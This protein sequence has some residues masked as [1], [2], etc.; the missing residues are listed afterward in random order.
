MAAEPK[1]N[2]LLVDDEPAN[3]LALEAVLAGLGQNLVK[4][5]S[6]AEALGCVLDQ[7]FA[8]IL[9]DVQ[10]PVMNGFETASRIRQRQRSAHTPIIFLTAQYET[11]QHVS[12][13]YAVGGV[14][15]LLKP[16]DPHV[17]RSKVS[18]FIDLFRMTFRLKQQAETIQRLNQDLSSRVRELALVNQQLAVASQQ[19]EQARDQAVTASNLK[20]SFLAN[21]SNEIRTPMNG[22]IGMIDSLLR[23]PLNDE[24]R[25]FANIIRDS[26]EVLMDIINDILDFSKIEAGRLDL[27]IVD[28]DTLHMVE[29]TVEL[30]A[31]RARSKGLSLMTYLAPAVPHTLRGDPSRLR[32]VLL[33]LIGNAIKFTE[34]GE[35]VLKVSLESRTSRQAFVRF[36][37]SDTGIGIAEQA[38]TRLFQPF[39]Q[40][41]STVGRRY[42]GTGLGLAISRHLVQL[43]GG[44]IGVESRENEG[45]T[46]WFSVPLELSNQETDRPSGAPLD[47]TDASVLIVDGPPRA[48]EII[49]DY[50]QAW[51]LRCDRVPDVRQ[52]AEA[53]GE[54]AKGGRPYQL[55][56]V[57]AELPEPGVLALPQAAAGDGGN[58]PTR[59]I[60]VSSREEQSLS[61]E[62]VRC[63][64]A[65]CLKKPIRQ[66][67]LYDCIA[68]VLAAAGAPSRQAPA[69]RAAAEP[70]AGPGEQPA[71]HGLILVAEDNPVNQKVAIF[72]LRELGFATHVVGSGREAV[73]A[74]GRGSYSAVL[75]D[76]QMPEMDGF[77]ATREIRMRE[78]LTGG[79]CLIIALTAH[80]IEGDRERCV[81]AGMDD[82]ISKPVTQKKL[83][84]V[85][86]RWL[87]DAGAAPANP[88]ASPARQ[89]APGTGDPIDVA[90]LTRACGADAVG[91]ILQMFSKSI[92]ALL[93]RIGN[94]VD[95][96]DGEALR[97]IAHELKGLCG[98]VSA[99]E[100][101]ELSRE[102]EQA[103]VEADWQKSASLHGR[104]ADSC[105][106]ASR[107]I[108]EMVRKHSPCR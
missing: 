15:Y 36:S 106:G 101:A 23:T 26:A 27:E 37:V 76:C 98:A 95:A 67:R 93:T 80:A 89:E 55:A 53:L 87:A 72:Q 74:V 12:Q 11:P 103:A 63:G 20:S 70:A 19:L 33:N 10:M 32:Q 31:V 48:R 78:A 22:V 13:G 62:A 84:E 66:S 43:M 24:Q 1:V 39:V 73:E 85:L 65:A 68:S 3:L 102:L 107:F 42:G 30:L 49:H 38:R 44:Q 81:A 6:G 61:Q 60:L 104:L 28:F 64:Y 21:M 18:V 97:D 29:D 8:V 82:Y 4:A 94:A 77:A 96:R 105:R 91:E 5:G 57:D 88:P 47:V 41:D 56:I 71:E 34:R 2:I 54:R 46:F 90:A 99:R 108:E 45:A 86:G 7:D 83:K 51:G 100:L 17:L 58:R 69:G 16:F 14:D 92:G 59:F 52:A 25:D 40:A 9:L 79:H 35:V 75:M 50:C